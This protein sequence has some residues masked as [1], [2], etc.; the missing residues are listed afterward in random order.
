MSETKGRPSVA[1]GTDGHHPLIPLSQKK[2]IPTRADTNP[3]AVGVTWGL[4]E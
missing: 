3:A 2:I 1:S 4:G